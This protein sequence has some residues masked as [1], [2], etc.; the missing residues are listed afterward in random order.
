MGAQWD[1]RW[2]E[3]VFEDMAAKLPA[4]RQMTYDALDT[5]MGIE[6]GRGDRPVAPGVQYK[7]HDYRPQVMEQN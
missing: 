6:L 5:Y 4:F 7:P 1:Y 2:A 3:D